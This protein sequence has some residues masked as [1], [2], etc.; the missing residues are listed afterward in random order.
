M[1]KKIKTIDGV[2]SGLKIS[3]NRISFYKDNNNLYFI[4]NLDFK[5]E[6]VISF[7]RDYDY[8]LFGGNIYVTKD[9]ELLVLNLEDGQL[10]DSLNSD[11]RYIIPL[12][13]D[14]FFASTYSRAEKIFEN[15]LLNSSCNIIADLNGDLSYRDIYTD[16]ILLSNRQGDKIGL[17]DSHNGSIMWS[18]ELNE[19][20]NGKSIEGDDYLIIPLLT[21]LLRLD[22]QNGK[23][24]WSKK[25]ALYHYSVDNT[26]GEL[27]GASNN[28]FEVRNIKDGE[29]KL[30]VE[31]PNDVKITPHLTSY[32]NDQLYFSAFEKKN[33]PIIGAINVHNGKLIFSEEVELIGDKS[34]RKGL[35]Q[36]LVFGNRLYVRD[37]IKT[38]HIYQR[39]DYPVA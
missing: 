20:I 29:I 16:C 27:Y 2:Y 13:S 38:L 18:N 3:D 28:Y 21:S 15:A 4:N 12:S 36:P 26:K 35:D 11:N 23:V 34:F 30:K 1:W 17:L 37:S 33:I 24:E 7:D 6:I 8:Q 31:M 5:E 22:K 19:K 39:V 10:V 14:R 32:H 25:E 9:H